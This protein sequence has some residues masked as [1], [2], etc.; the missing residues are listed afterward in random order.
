M[1]RCHFPETPGYWPATWSIIIGLVVGSK[2]VRRLTCW[3]FAIWLVAQSRPAFADDAAEL[4]RGQSSFRVFGSADGLYNV[5]ISSLAQD[6]DGLLW[7]ATDDGVYRFDGERF[8]HVSVHDGLR[9]NTINSLAIAPG[10]EVCAGSRN[11]L[12]CWDGAR[13]SQAGARGLPDRPIQAMAS[14]PGQLWVAT[15]GGGLYLREAAGAFVAVTGPRLPPT[16]RVMW[17][18]AEGLVVGNGDTVE[19]RARDGTWRSLGEV[20]LGHDR[21]TGVLRDR[22]GALWIRTAT[23]IWRVASGEPRAQDLSAGFPAGYVTDTLVAMAI[24]PRGDLV[25]AAGDG[26]TYRDHDRWRT[27]NPSVGLPAGVVGT[28][29]V[30]R[31]GSIWMGAAGLVQLRG[32]GLIEHDDVA[33]GLPGETVWSFQRD[34][35]GGMWIGTNRCLAH[36]VAQR[37]RCVPGTEGRIVS[38]IA[39]SPR[40]GIFLAGGPELTYIDEAG[41]ASALAWPDQPS[42][43][44]LTLALGPEGDLWIGTAD[45]VFR[46][47]GAVPGPIERLAAPAG[48]PGMR[49]ASLA[50]VGDQLWVATAPGGILVHDRGA[51]HAFDRTDGLLADRTSV[52]AG[53]RD[54]RICTAYED[55]LGVTCF[56]YDGHALTGVEHIGPAQGLLT[57]MVYSLGEDRAHRLWIGTGAGLDVVTERGVDH[58]D[59]R[60]GIAGNDS[61][62]NALLLDRDGS[63]WVGSSGGATHVFAQDYPGPPPAP[64]VSLLDGRLGDRPLAGRAVP[65]EPLE[66]S[67]D[68]G[69]LNLELAASSLIDP[70]RITYEVRLSP[71]EPAWSTTHQREVRYPALLP[72]TYRFEARAR[73]DAGDRGPVT[74]LRFTVLPAWWQT[75]WWFASA[76]GLGLLIV[77]AASAWRQHAVIG[78]R[79]RQ[80]HAQADASFRAVID[81]MPELISVYRDGALIYLNLASRQLLGIEARDG[82]W[83]AIDLA[84]RVH[85]DDLPRIAEI[86]NALAALAPGRVT[87][88]TELRMRSADG[89][90]RT[91]EVSGIRV[92]IAGLP[93][94]VTSGR[95][96]TERKR[97]HKKLLVSDRMASLGTLAAGIA[98]EIN[99]PLSYVTGNLEMIAETLADSTTAPSGATRDELTA[100]VSDARDGAERVRKIVQGLRSF[101]RSED[102]RHVPLDITGSVEAAIRFTGNEVRHRAEL[103]RELGPVPIVLG[104]DGRLTQVFINL[105]INASHAIPEGRSDHKRVTVR[106]RTD[107]RG[108]AVIEVEDTGTGMSPDVQ[109]RVFDPFFTTKEVGEGTGLGLSI[110]H[111]IITGLGGQISIESPPEH[112]RAEAPRPD[113][114]AAPSGTLVRVVLPPHAGVPESTAAPGRLPAGPGGARR[115]RVMLVD[116]EP[117]VVQSIERLLRNDYDIT[118]AHS[119]RDAIGY[120]ASGVRFDAIVSDVMM[121]AMSGIE[122]NEELQ[123]VAPDQAQRMIFLSGGVF[124]A[125]TRERLQQLGAPQLAK[126]VAAPELRAC[127][128]RM[129][130]D[131]SMSP[132]S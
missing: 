8:T 65:G 5:A 78:R 92:E 109:A 118:I 42:G 63:L 80:L 43:N 115:H 15:A 38:A 3:V 11:G 41:H 69:A 125:Q 36:A 101:T 93:T 76:A 100:A 91:C 16:V 95:D 130:T 33:S 74:E 128:M 131:T 124:T 50:V 84:S 57:G 40:G 116:D 22:Q 21:I 81:L 4:P 110:C 58:L 72:G 108:N 30:D 87:E 34:P 23:R 75:R 51:W 6:G 82:R 49:V 20:G 71:L 59:E 1:S 61:S 104:D 24:G 7:I 29:F 12:A 129:A 97:M 68:H 103:V 32:R 105:L 44:V 46:L 112:L 88:L 85:P 121:P 120:I 14:S 86:A 47:P 53:R 19:L 99:N 37:W 102:E 123:R 122:L 119:G 52:V 28:L 79:T 89:S 67:H 10:G 114:A 62:A 94:V 107:A 60:D 126:P 39:F 25:A 90:W 70:R 83:D 35:S 127:V 56:G 54:G 31:E 132:R 111:G 113:G 26:I 106:T 2:E 117:L 13:F 55:A 48:R 98:H 66:V 18:D 17:A 64:R 96:V 45:G 27:I 77:G 73:L 9:A